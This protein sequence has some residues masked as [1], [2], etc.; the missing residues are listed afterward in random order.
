M[1]NFS[2]NADVSCSVDDTVNNGCFFLNRA[3]YHRM[4]VFIAINLT[5]RRRRDHCFEK[6]DRKPML[7]RDQI[8]EV[9][10]AYE[11]QSIAG[12]FNNNISE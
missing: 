2:L 5:F 7:L 8:C 6:R 1:D 10:A 12:Q 11:V 4:K 3:L 9:I